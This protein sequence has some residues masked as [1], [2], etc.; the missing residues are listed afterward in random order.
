MNDQ[1]RLNDSA[2]KSGDG[3][4]RETDPTPDHPTTTAKPQPRYHDMDSLRASMMLLGLVF[5]V[6]WF[7]LPLYF[8]HTLSDVGGSTG[9]LYFFAW[10]HQFRMQVFFLIAGFF[11]CLL[12]RK[13][14]LKSFA[15][16]RFLRVVI[17]LALA[18]LTIYPLMKLQYLRGGLESGR[19]LSDEPLMTQYAEVMTTID[20]ANEWIVHLWF[21][22]CLILIYLI[23]WVLRVAS[24]WLIDRRGT[25]RPRLES[26]INR[27]TQSHFGPFVLAIPIGACMAYHLTWFGIDSGPLKSLWA[28]VFA[29]WVF[30]AVGWCLYANPKIIAVFTGP[31]P[32]YL[33]IG[34]ALSL[35]LCGYFNHLLNSQRLIELLKS[36]SHLFQKTGNNN[37]RIA[38]LPICNKLQRNRILARNPGRLVLDGLYYFN[39][40]L[41]H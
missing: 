38:Q 24:D 5:H 13:R 30:F 33:V 37:R 15:K 19:I 3:S 34:S 8:G 25:I 31:W 9:F 26:A 32:A 36:K 18:M 7:F 6:A 11:A 39:V 21:L 29:Y 17:P 10:V 1:S 27:V 35:L 16:N 28:G 12:V 20:W 23:A 22:E 2:L 4:H 40:Q 14:G 41:F